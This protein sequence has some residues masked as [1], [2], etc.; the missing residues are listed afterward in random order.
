MT[1][2]FESAHGRWSCA[3]TPRSLYFVLGCG[4][5][6]VA[7]LR[8]M[9]LDSVNVWGDKDGSDGALGSEGES[10]PRVS[11]SSVGL[12]AA[13]YIDRAPL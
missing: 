5:S 3:W 11:A 4:S 12:N 8:K 9:V 7:V 1:R 2:S 10:W 13:Q 6:S